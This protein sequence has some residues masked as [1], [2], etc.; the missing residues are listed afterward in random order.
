MP[1]K[2]TAGPLGAW[3][4]ICRCGWS[5]TVRYDSEAHVLRRQ[6]LQAYADTVVHVVEIGQELGA[7]RR[8]GRG[9]G[10]H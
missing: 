8:P 7:R 3:L 10:R 5:A 2:R 4:V 1:R 9:P 6:H